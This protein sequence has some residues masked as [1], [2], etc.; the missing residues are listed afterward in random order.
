[1]GTDA[2]P[3]CGDI[4]TD[5]STASLDLALSVADYFRLGV[6]DA[7]EIARTVAAEVSR[8]RETAKDFGLQ[9][10]DIDRMASAFEH[11]DLARALAV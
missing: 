1:M 7:R 5:D 11:H 4:D 3:T 9:P 2:H 10:T 6:Q 8:W